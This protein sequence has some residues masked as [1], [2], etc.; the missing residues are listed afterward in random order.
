MKLPK[1]SP[2]FQ[3]HENVGMVRVCSFEGGQ[4]GTPKPRLG[5]QKGRTHAYQAKGGKRGKIQ[6]LFGFSRP[7]PKASRGGKDGP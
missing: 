3:S 2:G 4:I 1:P 5:G 7:Y 6:L